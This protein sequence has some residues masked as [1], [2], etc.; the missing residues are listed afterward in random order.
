MSLKLIP[1]EFHDKKETSNSVELL[2]NVVLRQNNKFCHMCGALWLSGALLL[3]KVMH[4]QTDLLKVTG[5]E[6]ISS[7][8]MTQRCKT[9]KVLQSRPKEVMHLSLYFSNMAL[10]YS[11]WCPSPINSHFPILT[12]RSPDH[13]LTLHQHKTLGQKIWSEFLHLADSWTWR[14]VQDE[15]LVCTSYFPS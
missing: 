7:P 3:N 1:T 2:H 5:N 9:I 8:L 11:K 4:K 6:C 10:W 14:N 13:P 15:D 12:P